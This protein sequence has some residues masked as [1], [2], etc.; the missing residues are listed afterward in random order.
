MAP[1]I[2][3][4]EDR[5]RD[6]R[7]ASSRRRPRGSASRRRSSRKWIARWLAAGIVSTMICATSGPPE[8]DSLMWKRRQDRLGRQPD[9]PAGEH[10]HDRPPEAVHGRER[11]QRRSGPCPPRPAAGRRPRSPRSRRPAAPAARPPPAG[12]ARAA[13]R[14]DRPAPQGARPCRMT[15]CSSVFVSRTTTAVVVA[16]LV[17]HRAAEQRMAR[18]PVLERRQ[19][20]RIVR[21]RGPRR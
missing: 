1:V 5:R 4:P 17:D 14:I 19:R 13:P 6:G 15:L 7:G 9:D 8:S 2:A 12:P 11:H 18:Q 3:R 21:P 10:R 16:R 20:R